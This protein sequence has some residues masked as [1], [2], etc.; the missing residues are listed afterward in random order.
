MHKQL[1][2]IALIFD[3]EKAYTLDTY[4]PHHTLRLP[5]LLSAY[6]SLGAATQTAGASGF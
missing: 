4:Q 6:R 1:L 5:H 3:E 2:D